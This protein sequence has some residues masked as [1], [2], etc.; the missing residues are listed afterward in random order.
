M[1]QVIVFGSLNMDLTIR[2]E[3][4]P[5]QGETVE[6]NNFL[7]NPGGKGGNQA[8]A[9]AKFGAPTK[10]IACVGEDVFGKKLLEVLQGYRVDCAEV[11]Q[12]ETGQTGVAVITCHRGDNRIILS[13]GTNHELQ[14]ADVQAADGEGLYDTVF[15]NGGGQVG[16]GLVVKP[17]PGLVQPRFHLGDGQH[18]RPGLLALHGDGVPHEGVQAFAQAFGFCHLVHSFLFCR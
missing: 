11:R 14:A 5:Q 12:S 2:C 16:Q 15:L 18:D 1:K 17:F 3:R 10:M 9:A 6:G 8:V 7:S 4:M 13:P